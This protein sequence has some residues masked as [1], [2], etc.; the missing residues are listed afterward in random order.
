M[1]GD[2]SSNHARCWST[3]GV[4]MRCLLLAAAASL[5]VT[6]SASADRAF[7]A[8]YTSNNNGAIVVA[9]NTLMSCAASTSCSTA[10]DE[11]LTGTAWDNQDFN[12]T[13]VDID[14]DSSTSN[15]SSADLD[16]P[17]GAT[18]LYAGLYWSARSSS[19]TRNTIRLKAPGAGSYTSL[20]ASV[21][22]ISS[23]GGGFY[24]GI[25]NVT[26]R[27]QA[28]GAGSYTVAGISAEQ[29]SGN[30]AGWALVVAY[31]DPAQPLRNLTVY[32]GLGSIS[33]NS[34]AT[35]N[36]A[37]FKTPATGPVKTDLGFV[38]WEG[39]RGLTGD[40]ASFNGKA[41]SDAG[42]PATNFFNASIARHGANVATRNPNYLNTL[43]L[44]ADV[45]ALPTTYLANG[46]TTASIGLSTSGDVYAPGVVTFATELHAPQ[47][48]QAKTVANVTHPG[49]PAQEGDTL[50]Y[51]ISGTNTGQDGATNFTVTDP[52]PPDTTFA[53][54][55]V[56]SGPGLVTWEPAN[57]RVLAR[58]GTGAT[59]T[60]G[61]VLAPGASYSLTIEAVVG[62]V[63]A[64]GAQIE[65]TAT[66][67]YNARTLGTPLSTQSSVSSTVAAP[68]L[69]IAKSHTPAGAID[70][71]SGITYTIDV[72]NVGSAATRGTITMDDSLPSGVTATSASGTGWTCSGAVTCTR[73]D[74]IA[75]GATSTI[76]IVAR[77]ASNYSGDSVDNTAIVSGGGD[78]NLANNSA[79]DSGGTTRRTDLSISAVADDG[80]ID[81]GEQVT[82]TLTVR[83]SGPSDASGVAVSSTLD[84]GLEYVSDDGGCMQS[85]TTVNCPVGDL[86]SGA[87]AAV[88][89][90]ARATAAAAGSVTVTNASVGGAQSDPDTTNNADSASV[91]V[92][93]ADLA[94]TAVLNPAAPVAG[95]TQHVLIDA[96]NRGPSRAS[97]VV[98]T[99]T[100]P[101]GLSGVSASADG[102][103]TCTVS[104]TTVT[105]PVGTL[106]AGDHV[107]IDVQGTVGGS[108]TTV[109]ATAAIQG[110]EAD[111]ETSN[112]SA[113]VSAPVQGSADLSLMKTADRSTAPQGAAVSYT[114]SATN[115]GPSEATGVTITDHLP[116]GVV[117]DSAASGCVEASGTVT[118]AIGTLAAGD[119]AARVVTV[120]VGDETTGTVTNTAK[121]SSDTSDPVPANNASSASFTALP[122]GRMTV[123]SLRLQPPTTIP[124]TMTCAKVATCSGSATITLAEDAGSGG[125]FLPA[126]TIIASGPFSVS[127]GTAT[128]ELTTEPS[129]PEGLLASSKP[130]VTVTLTQTS[131]PTTSATLQLRPGNAPR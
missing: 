56:T 22:D 62:D 35:I 68:D 67:T 39:D 71:G 78:A 84:A 52:L 1:I 85:G 115:T 38:A 76:T 129:V 113:S 51:T 130:L 23:L 44:D 121:A 73:T 13:F 5:L 79:T 58:L 28:A 81:V 40:Q 24:Q 72:T 107:S 75:A 11:P 74:P 111:P 124:V 41:L 83:N 64:D 80:T 102:G 45:L 116:T 42:N 53:S 50:R 104:S 46:A 4:L 122:A 108:A 65:N 6:S 114:L 12:M 3:R 48:D 128:F 20:T 8:R 61:G 77:V 120:K 70:A 89:V 33:A 92:T 86:A 63:I 57:H 9:A 47:I 101:A 93:S 110:T 90:V 37:G 91:T 18:V 118:C 97:G 49:E 16:L 98:L 66:A 95:Q 27:V 125:K 112:N 127:A 103:V 43:S 10:R 82:F 29:G 2:G 7:N 106:A 60:A 31:R 69:S 59:S 117:F 55:A 19:T 87:D 119:S 26:S 32:D 25:S 99:S 30:H 123:V 100:V 109:S 96:V 15:S 126:G 17:S 21:L 94:V 54:A 14:G 131:G 36:V 88:H 34:S 105:C